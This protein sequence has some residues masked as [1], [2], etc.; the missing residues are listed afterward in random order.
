[1]NCNGWGVGKEVVVYCKAIW[2]SVRGI[3]LELVRLVVE[4]GAVC[5]KTGVGAWMR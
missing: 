4:G 2:G 3:G 1:M 5:F